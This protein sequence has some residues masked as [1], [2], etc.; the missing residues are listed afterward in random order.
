MKIFIISG[1]G[2]AGKTTLV[3]M[4]FRDKYIKKKFIRA[5]SYTTR[6]IRYDEKNGRDYYFVNKEEFL[7]LKRKKF[8]LESQKVLDNYYGTPKYFYDEAKEENKNLI[9]WID[10]KGAMYLKKKLKN[11]KIITIFISVSSED[12]LKKRLQKRFEEKNIIEKR[13]RLAKKEL[14]LSKYYDYIITNKNLDS[15]LKVFKKIL[16]ENL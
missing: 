11:D 6:K 5:I 10:V 16:K 8:F 13:L 1:P 12:E 3:N 15:S 7:D 9:L 4:L 14:N 2:G